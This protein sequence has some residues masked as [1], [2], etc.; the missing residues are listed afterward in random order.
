MFPSLIGSSK[1]S[2]NDG[3]QNEKAPFPSLIGSSKTELAKAEQAQKR[4]GF[5][6]S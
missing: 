1:T 2:Q 3:A 4:L 6:P 5:H